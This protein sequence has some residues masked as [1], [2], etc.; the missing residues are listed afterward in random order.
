MYIEKFNIHTED[1][2]KA[3]DLVIFT[4]EKE[5][6]RVTLFEATK[7]LNYS[8]DFPPAFSSLLSKDAVK[9]IKEVLK[10]YVD[11]KAGTVGTVLDRYQIKDDKI[12]YKV[13][14]NNQTYEVYHLQ[15]KR[16]NF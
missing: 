5:T 3:G 9:L 2:A 1:L 10:S 6:H 14:I 8:L 15:V 12:Y 11:I 4:N 16:H 13:L 7:K